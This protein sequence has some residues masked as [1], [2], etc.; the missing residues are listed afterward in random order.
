[1]TADVHSAS[2]PGHETDGPALEFPTH[3]A[4]VPLAID[5]L[6]VAYHTKPVLWDIDLDIPEG[7]LVAIAVAKSAIATDRKQKTN[8]HNRKK[9]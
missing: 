6:T 9:R 7:K 3:P 2:A 1:M 8:W 5:D 4:S